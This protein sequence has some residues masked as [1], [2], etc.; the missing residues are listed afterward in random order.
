MDGFY[1][2]WSKPYLDSK[3]TSEYRMHDFEL[4][5]LCLS[6][7]LWKELNGT[8]SIYADS[9]ALKYL[10]NTGILGLFNGAVESF[11][12]DKSINSKIFW[13]AGKLFALKKLT[14]P[15]AMIDLDLVVWEN[16]D[17]YLKES[18]IFVAHREEITDHV[19]PDFSKFKMKD[20]YKFDAE[21]NK[22]ILPCNTA[23][24]Y[25]SSMNFIEEYTDKSIDFMKNCL[26]DN[27]NLCPMVFAEQRLLPIIAEKL[28][29]TVNARFPLASDIGQQ[30]TFTHLWGHKNILKFNYEERFKYCNKILQRLETS[31]HDAFETVIKLDEVRRYY[32]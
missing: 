31:Y 15:K 28:G 16:F 27:D 4:L 17:K 6:L 9:K 8:V 19:Y 23:F 26:E 20:S 30:T 1:S 13:A 24:F 14:N 5:T 2:I 18:D 25:S 11:Q 32:E 12:V 10:E 22:E 29:L 21:W 7:S 3:K